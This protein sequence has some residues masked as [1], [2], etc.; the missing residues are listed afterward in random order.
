MIMAYNVKNFSELK[1]A[2]ASSGN[3]IDL[4][5]NADIDMGSGFV[6]DGKSVSIT[7]AHTNG[8]AGMY[9]LMRIESYTGSFFT[10]KDNASLTL[11]NITFLGNKAV[12]AMTSIPCKPLIYNEGILTLQDKAELYSNFG[13]VPVTELSAELAGGGIVNIGKKAVLTLETGSLLQYNQSK[14]GGG[15]LNYN[16]AALNLAGGVFRWNTAENGGG[17]ANINAVFNMTSGSVTQNSATERGAGIYTKSLKDGYFSI[18]GGGIATNENAIEGGGI[19]VPYEE[20]KFI[21]IGADVYFSGNKAK[22]SYERCFLD[23]AMYNAN[24]QCTKWTK[25]FSQGYNNYDIYYI[26]DYCPEEPCDSDD[27]VQFPNVCYTEPGVYHYTIRETS[28]PGNGWITDSSEYPVVVT[29]TDDGHGHLTAN[30]EYPEGKPKF[31]NK[32]K[33]E[34]VCVKLCAVKIAEGAPLKDGQFTFGLFD[35]DGNEIISAT[36]KSQ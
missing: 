30:V 27:N 22:K 29:V 17:F 18:T 14:L 15:V 33:P 25:P 34:S 23:D 28:E 21:H 7:S 24:I 32:Y 20:L 3:S 9:A 4:I 26:N 1:S 10:V 19:Y 35:K 6:I 8:K 11:S 36:N 13:G 2:L 16:G 5:I 12:S 31:I